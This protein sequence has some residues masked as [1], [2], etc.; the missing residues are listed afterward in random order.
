MLQI[1]YISTARQEPSEQDLEQILAASRRNNRMVQ[2]TGL[3]LAGGRRFLQAL[4]GPDEA[5]F[6]TFGRIKA[7]PRHYAVVELACKPIE[8]RA[9]GEW[10]MAYQPAGSSLK[11]V[12]LACEVQSIV[13]SLQDKSLKA[14]FTGFAALHARA[15]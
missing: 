11:G 7:D 10:A 9:F 14:Q 15:A 12:G 3:L 6:T 2:V 8:R 13:S 4:E 1:V 5:V